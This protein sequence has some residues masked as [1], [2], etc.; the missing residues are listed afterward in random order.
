MVSA[1]P[2]APKA[3]LG[4]SRPTRAKRRK[5][6][7]QPARS[8]ARSRRPRSEG[9][10]TARARRS[11]GTRSGST[12]REAEPRVRRMP[13]RTARTSGVDAG[14]QVG[15]GD[16]REDEIDPD[17]LA[18]APA[19]GAVGE[20]GEVGGEG[21]RRGGE[22]G[23]V[24][25]GAPGGERLPGAGVGAAGLVG[26]G[27]GGEG[28]G[29]LELGTSWARGR[30]GGRGEGGGRRRSRFWIPAREPY[31]IPR[32]AMFT[33]ARLAAEAALRRSTA[34][35][36]G[37]TKTPPSS[38]ASRVDGCDSPRARAAPHPRRVTPRGDPASARGAGAGSGGGGG[39]RQGQRARPGNQM[40]PCEIPQLRSHST[41][42]REKN[43]RFRA[44]VSSSS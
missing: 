20:G 36:Q 38:G 12:W 10:R 24:L 25:R 3:R 1:T 30:G 40:Q 4:T 28:A 31:R 37:F 23:E 44:P 27:G 8:S 7:A 16:G 18:S 11:S 13:T 43:G 33:G 15:A 26:L 41:K 19:G 21:D 29:S 39:R 35:R 34:P 17:G 32:K 22:G 6:P 42:I 5:A 9:G 2:S 14:G